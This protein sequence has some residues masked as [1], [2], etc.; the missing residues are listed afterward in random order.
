[1][2]H[3]ESFLARVRQAAEQGRQYRVHVEHVP[4]E[5][6]YLA[7]AA[8]YASDSP[9][10]SVPLAGKPLSSPTCLPPPRS[11]GSFLPKRRFSLAMLAA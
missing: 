5:I 1:M 7:L 3:R 9:W 8:I 11:S 2:S 6:G 10:K 4:D